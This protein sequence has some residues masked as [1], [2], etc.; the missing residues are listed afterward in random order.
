MAVSALKTSQSRPAAL[1][2]EQAVDPI[3][4]FMTTVAD[5]DEALRRAGVTR[6]SLRVVLSDAD[7][8][9]ALDT[10][11]EALLATP[12]RLEGAQSAALEQVWA[13]LEPW[14]E[15]LL[16]CTFN[17]LPFGYSVGELVFAE[18]ARGVGIGSFSEKPFEWF[19][20]QQ[21][22]TLLYRP[23][24]N[25]AGIKVDL[26]KFVLTVREGTYRNPYGE[27]LLSRVYWPWF[28]RSQGWRF[29]AKWL[30]RFGIPLLVGETSGDADAMAK[31]LARVV[32]DAAVAVGAG[33]KVTIA[34]QGGGTGHFEAFDKTVVSMF[35]RLI[36]GQTLTSDVGSGGS[37][38]RALGQVHNEVRIDR[39][40]AD[41]RSASRAIQRVVDTLWTLNGYSGEAPEFCMEDDTGLEGERAERDSK[42]VNAGIVKLTPAY[43]LRVY[44]FEEGDFEIPEAAAAPA[45]A[46]EK[47]AAPEKDTEGE[48]PPAAELSAGPRTTPGQAALDAEISGA[49][50]GLRAP[51]T[52]DALERAI[53]ESTSPEDLAVRLADAWGDADL[54]AFQ[55]VL[56]R[57][58]FAADVMGYS[59]AGGGS[60]AREPARQE[61]DLRLTLEQA[62]APRT[63]RIRKDGDAWVA[64]TGATKTTIRKDGDGW[65]AD[66]QETKQ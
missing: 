45:A 13:D 37:G 31:A 3:L 58:M 2:S 65:V 39:R 32:Q 59:H 66:Q 53:R 55:T 63:T 33:D 57:A 7:I 40:N 4:R 24:T 19:A 46:P 29:W 20:P 14:I 28:F 38:S 25:P 23:I 21:D 44:D 12:W 8:T 34:E 56:S 48:D 60:A 47:P 16:R 35:N 26:R 52:A 54:D 43:L 27:A 62:Q 41:I 42:L 50:R 22:G 51:I 18:K 15:P 10:R 9:A 36:L 5:P 11:K 30:E 17:A 64:E 61:L 1:F 6:T 49:L